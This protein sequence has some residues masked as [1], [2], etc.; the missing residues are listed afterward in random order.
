MEKIL[1]LISLFTLNTYAQIDFEQHI[2][3]DS[4]P[5]LDGPFALASGDIDGDGDKD[6][7]AT[8]T[9]GDKVVW[10]K[11][12]DGQGNFSEPIIISFTMNYPMGLSLADI[13]NDNDLDLIE[14]LNTY[15]CEIIWRV[16]KLPDPLFSFQNRMLLLKW[17]KTSKSPSP[18]ISAA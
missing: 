9:N 3:V 5:N 16:P 11:N 4:N 10:F 15:S 2:I 17:L 8:S 18:S 6:L 13:D 1:L 12:L 7:F 14:S